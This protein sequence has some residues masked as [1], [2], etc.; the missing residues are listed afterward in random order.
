MA[1]PGEMARDFNRS[2]QTLGQTLGQ[3]TSPDKLTRETEGRASWRWRE[4]AQ[5]GPAAIT[6]APPPSHETRGVQ[7]KKSQIADR[8]SGAVGAE[9]FTQ[10]VGKDE[11]RAG[12]PAT[13]GRLG[14]QPG[15]GGMGGPTGYGGFGGQVAA[16][17]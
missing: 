4:N 1:T 11:I 9:D 12:A 6:S 13:G 5:S 10:R 7:E 16:D 8:Q 15:G 14:A 17:A 3:G 2:Y